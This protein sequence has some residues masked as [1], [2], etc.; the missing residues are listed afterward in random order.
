MELEQA[1]KWRERSRGVSRGA[2]LVV[3]CIDPWH[4]AR[5]RPAW[6]AGLGASAHRHVDREAPNEPTLRTI[7]LRTLAYLHRDEATA[8][9]FETWLR[10]APRDAAPYREYAR[11]LLDAGRSASA[12]TV[13]QR[14]QRALGGTRDITVEMAQLRAATGLWELSAQSWRE[15]MQT[16]PYL[17]QA[18]VFSLFPTPDSVRARSDRS[19]ARRQSRSNHGARWRSSSFAGARRA[20]LERAARSASDGR[21][22]KGVDRVRRRGGGVR[23]VAGCARRIRC[24][25]GEDADARAGSPSGERRAERRRSERPR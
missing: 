4:R 9:A 10:T 7:Q 14:A 1:G 20:R 2:R 3:D 21:C 22:G 5:L 17:D 18:A 16:S 15:A 12:D 25:A 11:I 23:R 13:L 19:F 8:A 6:Q 24:R